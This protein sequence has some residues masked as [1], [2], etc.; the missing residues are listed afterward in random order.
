MKLA[1]I[2]LIYLFIY[3]WKSYI[4]QSSDLKLLQPHGKAFFVMF[5][6][7]TKNSLIP[8][9]APFTA[10]SQPRRRVIRKGTRGTQP[11][12]LPQRAAVQRVIIFVMKRKLDVM[13]GKVY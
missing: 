13:F 3:R 6:S 11:R 10:R 8:S 12:F 5:I 1:S 2:I 9:C 4:F 7:S